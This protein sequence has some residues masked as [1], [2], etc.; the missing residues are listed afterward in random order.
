MADFIK[1]VA[2]LLVGAQTPRMRVVLD[3][4]DRCLCSRNVA[5][6]LLAMALEDPKATAELIVRLWCSSFTPPTTAAICCIHCV[7]TNTIEH[8]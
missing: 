5:I 6:L 2:S 3:D 1:T 8:L 4:K 7:S